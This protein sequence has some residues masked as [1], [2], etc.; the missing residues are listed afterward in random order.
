[1]GTLSP[2]EDRRGSGR[3]RR[4]NWPHLNVQAL[5]V[6]TQTGPPLMASGPVPPEQRG[7]AYRQGMEE[8]TDLAWFGCG[9]STPLALLAQRTGTA[10]ANAGTIDHAQAPIGF[11]AVLMWEERAPSR[12]TQR[13]IRLEGK[14]G[15]SKATSFPG[16]RDGRRSIPR[17]GRGGRRY[18]CM[19][20]RRWKS[21]RKFRGAHRFRCQ[22]MSQL[23]AQVPG[24]LGDDLPGFLSPGRVRTPAVGIK[25][26]IFV[27]QGCFK[28]AAVQR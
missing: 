28:G 27:L 10:T 17:G 12:A 6:Q 22:L 21:R 4:K 20:V 16:R 7:R 14:V 13:P 18:G 9:V 15:P 3:S 26:L 19:L 11:S 5:A 1:M 24:P 2:R 23:Q 8:H 25:L